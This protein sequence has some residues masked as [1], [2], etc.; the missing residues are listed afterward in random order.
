MKMTNEIFNA[1][2]KPMFAK[3]MYSSI[4]TVN[5]SGNPHVSPIGSVFLIDKNKGYYL[6]KFT[7]SIPEN[8]KGNN[9]ATIMS[10][11]D[12]KWFWLKSL[13]KGSFNQPPAIRLV[14]KLGQL[15]KQNN[16]EAQSFKKR[17]NIFKFTKGYELLWKDMSHV[18]EFDIIDYKPVFIS[19]MTRI[20]FS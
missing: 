20:Q 6:E 2:I 14:V 1:K 15:R 16:N 7:K 11:N 17:V 5:E 9:I 4:A 3:A 13:I 18:R 8:L 12:G 10:V 19:K